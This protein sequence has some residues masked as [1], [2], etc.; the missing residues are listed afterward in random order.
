VDTFVT[1]YEQL[2]PRK[3]AISENLQSPQKLGGID[4]SQRFVYPSVRQPIQ[5]RGA[6]DK[7]AVVVFHESLEYMIHLDLMQDHC[8]FFL[9]FRQSTNEPRPVLARISRLGMG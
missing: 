1:I 6:S 9:P 5:L 7:F 2:G 8:V 4:E 3:M